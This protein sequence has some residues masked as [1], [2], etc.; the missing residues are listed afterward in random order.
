MYE[1]CM[2][3]CEILWC[4]LVIAGQVGASLNAEYFPPIISRKLDEGQQGKKTDVGKRIIS[5]IPN[6][7]DCIYWQILFITTDQGI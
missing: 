4:K 5:A 1:G 6:L 7:A 2:I 3:F